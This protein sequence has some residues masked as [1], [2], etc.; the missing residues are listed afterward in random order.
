MDAL[1]LE[2]EIYTQPACS[3]CA[4]A[5]RLLATKGVPFREILAPHG[6][7]ERA[8]AIRRSGGRTTVPQIFIG[9]EPIGGSD[10]LA[11]LAASGELDRKLGSA[12]MLAKP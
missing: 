5:K 7:A 12:T 1:T 6:S 2:I 4:R 8:D 3:Y 11:L 10:E 9:G